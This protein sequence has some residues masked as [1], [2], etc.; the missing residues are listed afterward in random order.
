MYALAQLT[1]SRASRADVGLNVP[2]RWQL[3]FALHLELAWA[4]YDAPPMA[5]VPLSLSS[6]QPP[7]VAHG[8]RRRSIRLCA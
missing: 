2:R 6:L 5:L 8:P 1:G 4:W 7:T 3:Y